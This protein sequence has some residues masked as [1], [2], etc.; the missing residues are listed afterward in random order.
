MRK[1]KRKYTKK[2]AIRRGLP[3]YALIVIMLL[4]VLPLGGCGRAAETESVR[5]GSLKGPTSLGILDL[6][7]RAE[8]GE[9]KHP[10][11]FRMAVGADELL[12][13]MAKGEL[14]MALIPA[15]VAAVLYHKTDRKSVV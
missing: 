1:C 6:M 7:D 9:T 11:E 10:Y 15:N 12:P 3:L 4:S 5:I 14:D 13:L 2:H 8:K